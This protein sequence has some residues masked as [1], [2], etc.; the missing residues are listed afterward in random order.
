MIQIT[1]ALFGDDPAGP[2]GAS[3]GIGVDEGGG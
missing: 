2:A 3:I 1:S